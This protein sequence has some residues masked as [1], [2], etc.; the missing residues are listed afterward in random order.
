MKISKSNQLIK[1][2]KQRL[3]YLD[4]NFRYHAIRAARLWKYFSPYRPNDLLKMYYHLLFT[5]ILFN[6]IMLRRFLYNSIGAVLL[7]TSMTP[8]I[9]VMSIL[10]TLNVSIKLAL[11]G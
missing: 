10:I 5:K 11:G 2:G 6:L 7:P 3:P 4:R 9:F 8:L 1:E